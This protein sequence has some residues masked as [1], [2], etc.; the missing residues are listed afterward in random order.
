MAIR[1]AK[2]PEDPIDWNDFKA[3]QFTRAVR[4]NA[5]FTHL[6]NNH[7]VIYMKTGVMSN[8]AYS[9]FFYAGDH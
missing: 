1:D 2:E 9:A 3:M 4:R 5:T 7:Y 8:C 6:G